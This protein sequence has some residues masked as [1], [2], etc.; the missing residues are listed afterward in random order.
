MHQSVCVCSDELYCLDHYNIQYNSISTVTAQTGLHQYY[1]HP[2]SSCLS[3][4]QHIIW[5]MSWSCWSNISLHCCECTKP[6]ASRMISSRRAA[7]IA[8]S[9]FI[10]KGDQII[11]DVCS[12]ARWSTVTRRSSL[13]LQYWLGILGSH[14]PAHPHAQT[15]REV[16]TS[17]W[18]KVEVVHLRSGRKYF[19]QCHVTEYWGPTAGTTGP[20]Y[21]FAAHQLCWLSNAPTSRA[22]LAV[23]LIYWSCYFLTTTVHYFLRIQ[24]CRSNSVTKKQSQTV[25]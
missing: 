10:S 2:S 5:T 1:N 23:Y 25:Y 20:V 16:A 12:W 7:H 8:S 4:S 21:Q 19:W 22:L 17:K 24:H 18:M 15:V 14:L 6:A 11:G 13:K 3:N 9:S